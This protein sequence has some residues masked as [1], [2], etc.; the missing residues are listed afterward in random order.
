MT[1]LNNKPVKN[2]VIVGGGTAG[3]MAAAAFSKLLGKSINVVLVESEEIGTVGVG[4][5]TVPPLILFN[6][7]LGINEQELLA[8]VKGTI[9][10]GISFENWKTIGESYIHPFGNTGRDTWAASFQ[11]FWRRGLDLG[12]NYPLGDY[13]LECQA[14]LQHKFA[15]LPNSPM[16]YAYH[17]DAGRYAKF[18]R[19]VAEKS[20]AV[21]IEGKVQDVILNDAHSIESIQLASGESVAGDFFIDCTGFR[22]LLIEQALHTGYEDWSHWLPC[23]SALAVQ[24]ESVRESV[25]YT[26]SIAHTAGW[27]WQI[28]LQHRVGNGLVYCSEYMSDDEAKKTLLE[29]VE[30]RT[31]SEPKLI[32]FKTGQRL[33][34][35]NKNCVTLGLASGFIEPLESTSIHLIQRGITRLVQMFPFDGIRNCDIDEYN[36]QMKT[37]VES[38]RDFIIMHYHLTQRD[39]SEFWRYCKAM[40]VPETLTHRIRLFEETG[41][42]FIE[43]PYKLFAEP[44]W[45][46]VMVGQGVVP[47]NYHAV[48]NEMSEQE[49]KRFLADMRKA[50]MTTVQKMPSHHDYLQHFCKAGAWD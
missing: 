27:R 14:A 24:T 38:I 8:Y 44:S 39:D 48:A 3:W 19:S 32:R 37:E 30:G 5:A 13:S 25:P 40:P 20:G 2:L 43:S 15:H 26:R 12:V 21:R 10:L 49:L 50:I 28:P 46:H 22:A 47:E 29:Q 16:T 9:K 6:R 36:A 42:I 11:H 45:L 18:L 1:Q 23:D 4:E 34:H 31:T 35:W 41:K 7:Y 33:K 17:I